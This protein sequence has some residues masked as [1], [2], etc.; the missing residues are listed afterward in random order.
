MKRPQV[1][2]LGE[3]RGVEVWALQEML[4]LDGRRGVWV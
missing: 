4:E 3:K 1:P 2:E